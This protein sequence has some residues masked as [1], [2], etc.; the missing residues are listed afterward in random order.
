MLPKS[1]TDVFTKIRV[2]F[3]RNGVFFLSPLSVSLSRACFFE[4]SLPLLVITDGTF[5]ACDP[6]RQ[7]T[8]RRDALEI[9]QHNS[10][11]G[12][13]GG[14][15]DIY[16]SPRY[17]C[18]RF[19]LFALDLLPRFTH[20]HIKRSTIEPAVISLTLTRLAWWYETR[21]SCKEQRNEGSNQTLQALA[22]KPST[23]AR[24]Q[25]FFRKRK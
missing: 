24:K 11:F 25:Q 17:T 2:D 16:P 23:K 19:A 21:N 8:R 3:C 4:G 22:Q 15:T 7:C 9:F 1:S 10:D 13:G 6:S 18:R 20:C 12:R 14:D 5:R